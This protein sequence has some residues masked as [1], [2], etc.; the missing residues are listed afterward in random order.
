MSFYENSLISNEKEF[1]IEQHE[2]SE[3]LKEIKIKFHNLQNIHEQLTIDMKNNEMNFKKEREN[4]MIEKESL[5][6]TIENYEELMENL[7]EIK[8]EKYDYSKII[9]DQIN[10]KSMRKDNEKIENI[11]KDN[12]NLRREIEEM[13]KKNEEL[14]KERTEFE[15]LRVTIFELSV[16]FDG[17]RSKY[18][19]TLEDLMKSEQINQELQDKINNDKEMYFRVLNTTPNIESTFPDNTNNEK[20]NSRIKTNSVDP[21]LQ[22]LDDN[23]KTHLKD[24]LNSKCGTSPDT[25]I[26]KRSNG[27]RRMSVEHDKFKK[28]ITPRNCS[29]IPKKLDSNDNSCISNI[30]LTNPNETIPCETS[31]NK[32]YTT[33]FKLNLNKKIENEVKKRRESIIKK[34]LNEETIKKN[35][36]KLEKEIKLYNKDLKKNKYDTKEGYELKI[37]DLKAKLKEEEIKKNKIESSLNQK[38][39]KFKE[40]LAVCQKTI[41]NLTSLNKSLDINFKDI[42]AQLEIAHQENTLYSSKIYLK[43]IEIKRLTD[44]NNKL[45]QEIMVLKEMNKEINNMKCKLNKD[46]C[47]ATVPLS[48]MV[49]LKK[50]YEDKL[51]LNKMKNNLNKVNK[52]IL[53]KR[54]SRS[55][56]E[57]FHEN[58]KDIV[59]KENK[60]NNA[61]I[62]FLSNQIG[63]LKK[64]FES[65][66][67]K[68]NQE[69]DNLLHEFDCLKTENISLKAT[70]ANLTFEKE[71][72]EIKSKNTINF[73]KSH[74]SRKS[75]INRQTSI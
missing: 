23:N 43:N 11:Q 49:S 7:K 31:G 41:H 35:I 50:E 60:M 53:K 58:S 73:L 74:L 27:I 21:R 55:Y 34:P 37:K 10:N 68:S 8:D 65:K 75:G 3:E 51:H 59:N 63:I 6:K 5:K 54:I 19:K 24:K 32:T 62:R 9:N 47:E 44:N 36:E 69:R 12:E 70:I 22:K 2:L 64:E 71:N 67:A 40:E 33:N 29:P 56:E 42:K 14:E 38:V 13:R 26:E 1:F 61:E 57:I 28:T 39:D 48:E 66:L 16:E 4:W 30:M 15:K 20:A 52:R 25:N 17:L 45:L 18:S 72:I 46:D